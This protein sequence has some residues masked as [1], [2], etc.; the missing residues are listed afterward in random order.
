[1]QT[2]TRAVF[3]CGALCAVL[4]T[5]SSAEAQRG[6]RRPLYA[7]GGIGPAAMFITEVA[8][9][10]DAH[11]RT[12]GEFGWHPSGEDSGF[13]LAANVTLVAGRHWFVFY[14]GL[15]L[16]GDIEVWHNRDVAIQLTPSGLVGGGIVDH[17]GPANTFGV[18]V[19]QPAF[20]VKALILDRLLQIWARP[21]AFD[22]VLYPRYFGNVVEVDAIYS[23]M[24]GVFFAFG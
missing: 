10:C 4:G 23:F 5:T 20:G 12:E 7:G 19:F 22:F 6:N 15:R 9:C 16:G 8:G 14:P 1:M 3:V 21:V 2:I 11:F 18:L 17:D 13:F 24:A